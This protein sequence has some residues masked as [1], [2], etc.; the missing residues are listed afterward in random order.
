M[1]KFTFMIISALI[2]GVMFTGCSKVEMEIEKE[3]TF[4]GTYSVEY[5]NGSSSHNGEMTIAINNGKYSVIGFLHNQ[6]KFSGNYSMNDD[7]IIFEI[8]VW[9][10]DY[11]DENGMG[12][13]LNF[14]AFIVPQGE[15]D[16]TFDGENLKFSKTYDGLAHY[17]WVFT[18]K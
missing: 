13:V 9:K 10:T 2:C 17:E 15:Y 8:E 7:K 11:I 18:R 12:I 16:Y 4:T 5:F 1:K 6:T 3:G 14:D